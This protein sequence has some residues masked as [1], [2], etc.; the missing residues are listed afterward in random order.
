MIRKIPLSRHDQSITKE[1][2]KVK[3]DGDRW[4]YDHIDKSNCEVVDD[5]IPSLIT[6]LM[7]TNPNSNL[8]LSSCRDPL[9]HIDKRRCYYSSYFGHRSK[10][11][12]KLL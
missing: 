2:S 8:T 11:L 7:S 5:C 12:A 1:D 4:M 3:V 9:R 10:I 6:T